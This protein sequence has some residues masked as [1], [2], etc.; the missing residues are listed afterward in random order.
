MRISS[1]WIKDLNVY[2]GALKLL[3][4][5]DERIIY[6]HGM[7]KTFLIKI[8]YLK[9]LNENKKLEKVSI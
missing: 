8:Q 7:W 2:I 1:K 4:R 6:N 9:A 5:K 3:G